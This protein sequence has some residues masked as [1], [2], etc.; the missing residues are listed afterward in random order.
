MET[1]WLKIDSAFPDYSAKRLEQL[2]EE[3]WVIIDKTVTNERYISYLLKQ[4]PKE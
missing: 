3:G 4:T 1:Q 2:L